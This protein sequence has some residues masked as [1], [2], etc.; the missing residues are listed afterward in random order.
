MP[1]RQHC[2]GVDDEESK[3]MATKYISP[4]AVVSPKLYWSL[5]AVLD[6]Q[7]PGKIALAIGRWDNDP[8]LAMRWNG[9][10]ENGPIG[11][12][13]SRGLPT[14]F[15]IPKGDYTEAILKLLPKDKLTLVRNFIPEP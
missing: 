15:I 13:Q 1:S 4:T 3:I 8:V 7:G 5:I 14:W 9:D 12:P 6:D 11:N 10:N 2:A